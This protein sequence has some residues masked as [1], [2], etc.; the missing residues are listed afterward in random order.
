MSVKNHKMQQKIY[1]MYNDGYT[2]SGISK[3]LGLPIFY[4]QRTVESLMD[5]GYIKRKIEIGCSRGCVTR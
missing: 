2:I 1:L 5:S 4:V 3:K